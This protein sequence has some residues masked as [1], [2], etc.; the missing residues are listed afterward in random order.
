MRA[1]ANLRFLTPD[2]RYARSCR[3]LEITRPLE[4][5]VPNGAKR[6]DCPKSSWHAGV[7]GCESMG[8]QDA[9]SSDGS[10]QVTCLCHASSLLLSFCCCSDGN[11]SLSPSSRSSTA[12]QPFR[13]WSGAGK[14]VICPKGS[15]V[16]PLRSVVSH[17]LS[18][19]QGAQE[20]RAATE[21]N[22]GRRRRR[23]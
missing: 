14:P 7:V 11:S 19:L 16:W 17:C 6:K 1:M 4:I 10:L 9:D 20:R 2:L 15:S 5:E 13:G 12:A 22:C 18:R 8:R 21:S 3:L 23:A